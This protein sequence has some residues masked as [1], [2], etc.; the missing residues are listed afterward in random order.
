MANTSEVLHVLNKGH[1]LVYQGN[2]FHSSIIVLLEHIIKHKHLLGIP[3]GIFRFLAREEALIEERRSPARHLHERPPGRSPHG[4]PQRT[5]PIDPRC[6]RNKQ[7]G[8]N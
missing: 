8:Y 1:I 2:L 7:I 3:C 4:W 6:C 5:D